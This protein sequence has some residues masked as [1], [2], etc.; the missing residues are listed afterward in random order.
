[1]Y[2]RIRPR[3][4]QQLPLRMLF[5]PTADDGVFLRAAEADSYRGLVAAILD[6]PTYEAGDI[7]ARLMQRLRLADDVVLITQ[8]AGDTPVSVSDRDAERNHQR[9]LGRAL[10]P[11]TRPPGLPLARTG[12]PTRW[13]L[14]SAPT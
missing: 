13:T 8:V 3:D 9:L 6:D 5:Q 10:H 4:E 1:M 11:L 7:E 12:D 2:R 14:R